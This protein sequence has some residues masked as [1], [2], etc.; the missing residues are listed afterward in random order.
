[1]SRYSGS[2]DR[3]GGRNGVPVRLSEQAW[4]VSVS[5]V[6]LGPNVYRV[7]RPAR[8]LKHA[9]LYEERSGA[10]FSVDKPAAVALALAW[11]LAARSPHSLVFLPV[12]A[13]RPPG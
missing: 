11:G 12:R 5:H 4:P 9:M 3:A 13:A 7:V 10:Q 1:M 6:R 8:A 2:G